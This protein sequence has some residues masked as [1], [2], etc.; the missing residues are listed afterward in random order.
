MNVA[1]FLVLSATLIRPMDV[2]KGIEVGH[3]IHSNALLCVSLCLFRA[4]IYGGCCSLDYCCIL[5]TLQR[6]LLMMVHCKC[7]DQVRDYVK[8]VERCFLIYQSLLVSGKF[9]RMGLLASFPSC[10]QLFAHVFSGIF[11]RGS[12]F[13]LRSRISIVACNV[14]CYLWTKWWKEVVNLALQQIGRAHV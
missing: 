7:V 4:L 3:N 6:P 8:S 13:L 11:L 2:G 5:L 14:D 12:V 9:L 1:A 10:F